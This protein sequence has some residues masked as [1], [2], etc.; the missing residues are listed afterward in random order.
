MVYILQR[1]IAKNEGLQSEQEEKNCG[2]VMSSLFFGL[3]LVV[4]LCNVIMDLQAML[5]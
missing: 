2:S 1:Q 3:P 4:Y 5:K